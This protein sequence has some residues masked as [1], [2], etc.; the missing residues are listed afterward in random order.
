MKIFGFSEQTKMNIT[1]PYCWQTIDVEDT[2]PSE[3]AVEFVADCEVC[4]RPIRVVVHWSEDGDD[5]LLDVEP[6]S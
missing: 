1:C 6:E 2:L 4:C 3:E 5:F